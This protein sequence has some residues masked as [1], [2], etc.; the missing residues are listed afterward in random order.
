LI[1]A[2][3]RAELDAILVRYEEQYEAHTER[4][5]RLLARR[6]DR[7]RAVYDLAEVVS[8]RK[9]L[10]DVA[11]ALQCMADRDFGRCADCA[12]DIP[13]DRLATR[14][15]DRSCGRCAVAIPA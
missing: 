9:A 6:G 1:T 10:A 14:P 11:R 2:S 7:R 12:G 5:G 4:L 15:A 13:I 3:R 8:C